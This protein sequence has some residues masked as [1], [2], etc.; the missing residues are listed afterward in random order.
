VPTRGRRL[1]PGTIPAEPPPPRL[2]AVLREDLEGH[3]RELSRPGFQALAVHRIGAWARARPTP[4]GRFVGLLCVVVARL[5]RRRFGIWVHPDARLGRR[6]TIGH[7]GGIAI[8]ANA[9]IGDDCTLL[10]GARIGSDS[11]G[12]G[13]IIGDRVHVGARARVA[14]TARV[15]DDARV[16]PNAVVSDEVPPGTTALARPSRTRRSA[17]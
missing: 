11:P 13:P 7:Q 2:R 3:W 17:T 6:L 4:V 10:Q 8:G 9:T 16:G 15:G 5:V 14:G 1:R 12:P